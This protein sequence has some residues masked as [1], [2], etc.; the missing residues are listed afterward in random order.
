M[1]LFPAWLAH[2][3]GMNRSEQDRISISFNIIDFPKGV[4]IPR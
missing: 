2:D 4:S 3:V 1:L